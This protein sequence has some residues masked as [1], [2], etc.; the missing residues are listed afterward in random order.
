[1]AEVKADQVLD[2]KGELCPMPVVRARLALDKLQ[3]GQVLQVLATDPASCDDFPAFCRAQG[4]TLVEGKGE[5]GTY[6][7]LIR[8][9]G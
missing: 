6:V 3:R 5:H 1:M 7:F 2:T 9:G 8:K 4:H